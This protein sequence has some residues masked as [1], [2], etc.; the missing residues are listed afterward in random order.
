ML[1]NVKNITVHYHKVAS[2]N[3]EAVR[4]IIESTRKSVDAYAVS[5]YFSTFYQIKFL[6]IYK[7]DTDE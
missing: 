1:L 6:N 2:L 7:L 5:A 3:L 4:R